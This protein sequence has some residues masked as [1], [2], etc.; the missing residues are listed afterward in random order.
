MDKLRIARHRNKCWAEA[1]KRFMRINR[2][3]LKWAVR[4]TLI[5]LLVGVAE[6]LVVLFVSKPLPWVAMIPAL[7]P[8]NLS[9]HSSHD[10]GRGANPSGCLIGRGPPKIFAICSPHTYRCGSWPTAL[11]LS[12]KIQPLPSAATKETNVLP[13][14]TERMLK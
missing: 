10:Q 13:I 6:I 14:V 3:K 12:C 8:H 11:Q 7:I 5:L 2:Q 9:Y 4:M 1:R